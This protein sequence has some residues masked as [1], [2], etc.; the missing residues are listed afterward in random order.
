MTRFFQ[1]ISFS[2]LASS[3][4]SAVEV[5]DKRA[6]LPQLLGNVNL[7]ASACPDVMVNGPGGPNGCGPH[8]ESMR[9]TPGSQPVVS[10][11]TPMPLMSSPSPQTMSPLPSPKSESVPKAEVATSTAPKAMGGYNAKDM[12]V[13]SSSTMASPAKDLGTK[14]TKAPEAPAPAP[15]PAP[16]LC[17]K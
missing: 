3:L 8:P 5:V 17:V 14:E 10:L 4:C 11:P 16:A 15:A 12:P 7:D 9:T 13:Q 1:I 2:V 6:L